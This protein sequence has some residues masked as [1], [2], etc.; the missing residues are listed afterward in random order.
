MDS[1]IHDIFD[2]RP[3]GTKFFW[4]KIFDNEQPSVHIVIW[5]NPSHIHAIPRPPRV[6]L[7][8][9]E[10]SPDNLPLAG[11]MLWFYVDGIYHASLDVKD[12]SKS[13]IIGSLKDS[14]SYIRIAF[15]SEHEF[16]FRIKIR[17]PLA[18]WINHVLKLADGRS[19]FPADFLSSALKTQN[20]YFLLELW[21]VG[22]QVDVGKI[23]M[24]SEAPPPTWS[25]ENDENASGSQ[26]S[27]S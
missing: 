19:W 22:Q 21:D 1:Y 3:Y 23:S 6:S 20:E 13:E 5:D 7:R 16:V 12:S 11:I 10:F 4:A 9:I 2:S 25:V 26:D 14:R 24:D 18:P 17:N 8:A 15:F 27:P